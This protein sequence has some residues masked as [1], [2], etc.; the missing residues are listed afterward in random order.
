MSPM[1][2][3][4]QRELAR[5]TNE[6]AADRS[7]VS[8]ENQRRIDALA[9][10]VL[11]EHDRIVNTPP[12]RQSRRQLDEDDLES[13]RRNLNLDDD[14]LRGDLERIGLSFS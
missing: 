4:Q 11:G 6:V 7:T 8:E 1:T 3:E 10:E 12:P 14:D 2:S 5:L 13:V 9:R